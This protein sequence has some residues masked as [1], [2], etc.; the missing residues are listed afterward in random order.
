MGQKPLAKASRQQRQE[1][2]H[3][4][5]VDAA[6]QQ[7][8]HGGH[9]IPEVVDRIAGVGE[10]GQHVRV[11]QG[12]LP[13]TAQP[14]VGQDGQGGAL[15]LLGR[16]GQLVRVEVKQRGAAVEGH[17]HDDEEPLQ[18]RAEGQSP[19]DGQPRR[20]DCEHNRL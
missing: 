7:H 5:A 18:Q 1:E 6:P 11:P 2:R 13:V 4:H 16:L 20:R 14:D 15:V 3:L 9:R 8:R 10:A 17:D 12:D 19:E